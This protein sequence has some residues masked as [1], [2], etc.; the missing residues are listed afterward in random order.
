MRGSMVTGPRSPINKRKME[1]KD[2]TDGL[3]VNAEWEKE[4]VGA[5]MESALG[6]AIE[7]ASRI[8]NR[9]FKVTRI[10]IREYSNHGEDEPLGMKVMIDAELM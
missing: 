5:T 3:D 9:G 1:D 6:Q 8:K 10:I 4:I 7:A 2:F